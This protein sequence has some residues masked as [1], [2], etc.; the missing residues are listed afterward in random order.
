MDREQ[1]TSLTN[2]VQ[3][4]EREAA[5]RMPLA[6][7]EILVNADHAQEALSALTLARSGHLCISS[8]GITDAERQRLMLLIDDC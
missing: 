7:T 5:I 4:G 3:S 8:T 6:R 1:N 2:E